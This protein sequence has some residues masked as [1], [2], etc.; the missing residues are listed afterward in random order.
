MIELY[1]TLN[2]FINTL[3]FDSDFVWKGINMCGM[4]GRRSKV[5]I[6]KEHHV[7]RILFNN[8]VNEK[9][10]TVFY[11]RICCQ[12]RR[13]SVRSRM[14]PMVL[15]S[16]LNHNQRYNGTVKLRRRIFLIN[17]FSA[18]STRYISDT[19]SSTSFVLYDSFES[20]SN[21]LRLFQFW[22]HFHKPKLY[23]ETF[24]AS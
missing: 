1:A 15:R 17:V 3:L 6:C 19:K 2:R 20:V 11:Q 13:I 21:V 5:W 16:I 8:F 4:S 9:F 22:K 14:R 10:V 24:L 23:F 7:Y 12:R 18:F